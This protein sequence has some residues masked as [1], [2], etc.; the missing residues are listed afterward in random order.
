MVLYFILPILS[1]YV[2]VQVL[3]NGSDA[4]VHAG[5]CLVENLLSTTLSIHYFG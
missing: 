2:K 3:V 1:Q 4:Y 5:T